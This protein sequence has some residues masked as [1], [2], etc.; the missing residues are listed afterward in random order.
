[1]NERELEL[2]LRSVLEGQLDLGKEAGGGGYVPRPGS[3][4]GSVSFTS[5]RSHANDDR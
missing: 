5:S 3:D 4:S 2:P 1:M